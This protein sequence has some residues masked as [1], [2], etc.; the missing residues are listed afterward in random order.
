[1]LAIQSGIRYKFGTAE[2]AIVKMAHGYRAGMITEGSTCYALVGALVRENE[3]VLANSPESYIQLFQTRS[4]RVVHAVLW[5]EGRLY[6][7][8]VDISGEDRLPEYVGG[9]SFPVSDF[10]DLM[11]RTAP[12]AGPDGAEPDKGPAAATVDG[13]SAEQGLGPGF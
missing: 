13:P 8:P 2:H 12:R 1:M 7:D 5:H 11:R 9:L 6:H 3:A 10:L 4:G